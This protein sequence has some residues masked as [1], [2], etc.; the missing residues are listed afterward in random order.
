MILAE[1]MIVTQ[2]GMCKLDRLQKW[3]KFS[4]RENEQPHFLCG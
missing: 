4:R 1:K 2:F 3:I